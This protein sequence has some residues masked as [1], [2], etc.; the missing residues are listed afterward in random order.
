[1]VLFP[2]DWP[3]FYPQI[4][5]SAQIFLLPQ[6]TQEEAEEAKEAK[7]YVLVLLAEA[8]FAGRS[9]TVAALILTPDS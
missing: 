1:M 8:T 3:P 4:T 5:Q 2:A 7:E 9:F 6:G